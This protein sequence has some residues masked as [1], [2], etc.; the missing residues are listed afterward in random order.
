MVG[1]SGDNL[2]FVLGLPRSGTTLL[3]A[4][5][6]AHDEVL[7]P[8]EPWVMLA[9]ESLGSTNTSH[10]ADAQVIGRAFRDF[11]GGAP[12]TDA[13]R[14]FAADLYNRRLEGTGKSV[15][16][17]K[18]PRYYHILPFVDRLFPQA[19]FI[20][21][22]RDPFDVAASY[23]N[24]WGIDLAGK[25]KADPG[26]P[27]SLDLLVGLPTLEAFASEHA[28]RVHA[29]RYEDLV[30]DA[31]GALAGVYD[32]LGLKAAPA[33]EHPAD[34][35]F[36]L[37]NTTVGDKKIL[38]TTGVHTASVGAGLES[39]TE[40]QLGSIYDAV[41]GRTLRS[42]GY[43]S[44]ADALR[45]RGIGEPDE[46]ATVARRDDATKQLEDRWSRVDSGSDIEA[47][48]PPSLRYHLDEA[49]RR[50]DGM[51]GHAETLERERD[52]W[53]E[54]H[55]EQKGEADRER[56]AHYDLIRVHTETER[57]FQ[58]YKDRGVRAVAKELAR[59]V[60]DAFIARV[61]REKRG[62]PLPSITLITPCYNAQETIRET[63]ESVLS[64]GFKDL[65]YIVV[66][67][68]STDGT[69]DIV[70]EYEDRLDKIISEP[71]EG[72]YDAIGKGFDRGTGE[73]FMYLNADDVLEPRGLQRVGEHFRDNP[74]SHVCYREDTITIGPWR[75]PNA[76]QPARVNMFS[77][78]R[79]HILFQD[80]VAF[81]KNAYRQIGGVD[82]S[83][84]LAGD[85]DL[86]LRLSR[87]FRLDRAPGHVSSFRIR[88]GQLSTDM[89]AYGVE[90][91]QS[92]ARFN[93]RMRLIGWV[94]RIPGRVWTRAV[95][96]AHAVFSRRRFFY[97][98][99][100]AGPPAPGDAPDPSSPAP[101]CPLT[102]R[103]MD[104]L[105]FTSR[106]TRFEC[107]LV[108]SVYYN[109]ESQVAVTG[110]RLE[111]DALNELYE[112]Y[113]SSGPGEP[114]PPPEGVVSPYRGW[115]DKR[116]L[117]GRVVRKLEMPFRAQQVINHRAETGTWGQITWRDLRGALGGRVRADDSAVRF[118]D[119]GCFEGEVLDEL[120]EKTEWRLSGLEPNALAVEKARA[121]GLDVYEAFI[122][123]AVNVIPESERFD[124]IFLGQVIE[125]VNDPAMVVR[126]LTQL[127]RPGGLLVLSTPNL[128]SAQA[129]M[130][131]PTWSHW[132]VP[133]HRVLFGMKSMRELGRVCALKTLKI[134]THSNSFWSGYSVKVNEL[135]VA[136]S[137]PHTWHPDPKTMRTAR[138]ISAWSRL[139]WNW[140]GKGD[141]LFAVYRKV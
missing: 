40:S 100:F 27:A 31:D 50:F 25:A 99:C 61:A 11:T 72:M 44:T 66:D 13:L 90:Q 110:P 59:K 104:R 68:A 55:D 79:G 111:G 139:L 19:K 29:L 78:L 115:H 12:P 124:V 128:D 122:E 106:D 136:G 118:L 17:D 60:I 46:S 54:R 3:C 26:D 58:A 69:M 56:T 76:A 43:A 126:R 22:K 133:Y 74:K 23:Q 47:D 67:G 138:S 108:S 70:R 10:P 30:A 94:R 131:G 107:P 16:I 45:E 88:A 14:R 113:Y 98:V 92:R 109:D 77:L 41:G 75:F 132:H 2:V 117:L 28:D 20:W 18:T 15:L 135:G 114:V 62:G 42:I 83:M 120:R 6:A 105:L 89:D 119:A 96:A 81:R 134:R 112:T 97:P 51:R 4:L 49:E 38:E 71:D 52:T 141:Y 36:E 102:G 103:P 86:W 80:G 63:I 121:K 137:A 127:L 32:F 53:I 91:R 85:Y 5:L 21:L 64:Q 34:T 125:H 39:L 101:L 84:R 82:R 7:C 57:S 130:F 48:L 37:K 95:N 140:R 93:D 1:Q 87:H 73:V 129:R 9:L 65:Q 35:L 123:D 33:P 116:W 8:P 24:T